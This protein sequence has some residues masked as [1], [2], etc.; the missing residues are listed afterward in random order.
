MDTLQNS[1][2]TPPQPQTNNEMPTNQTATSTE[3]TSAAV[4]PSDSA[5]QAAIASE[6]AA[7]VIIGDGTEAQVDVVTEAEAAELKQQGNDL[8]KTQQ[9]ETAIAAYS[10]ALDKSTVTSLK[11]QCFGNRAACFMA[12]ERYE[13]AVADC[14][15]AL[16]L[17]DK[18]IKVLYRRCDAYERLDRLAEALADAKKIVELDP[19]EKRAMAKAEQ[20]QP[21]VT[22]RQ[23]R[24]RQEMINKLKGMGN[25]ILGKFGLSTEN[26][27]MVQDPST[28][29]YNISFQK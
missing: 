17:D 3:P 8:F 21:V 15:A 20:L 6:A 13:A 16:D 9:F 25:S 2:D 19:G 18:Y 28:G 10:Q 22:E 11:S 5:T 1:V 29:S 26:F 7:T 12:L 23:E 4:L 24:E 14:T 27:K